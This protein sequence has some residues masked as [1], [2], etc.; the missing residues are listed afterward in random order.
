[1]SEDKAKLTGSNFSNGV[2][3]S[4][5]REDVMLLGHADG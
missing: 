2:A 5:I 1:M 4:A 3:L